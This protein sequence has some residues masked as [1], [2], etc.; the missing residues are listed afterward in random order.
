M[1]VALSK[2]GSKFYTSADKYLLY[3][4][5]IFSGHIF[6]MNLELPI[7]SIKALIV[8]IAIVHLL[9]KFTVIY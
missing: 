2:K 1:E 5:I 9:Q 4:Q 7:F 6:P 3:I 8:K